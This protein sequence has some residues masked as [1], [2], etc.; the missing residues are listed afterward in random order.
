MGSYRTDA[1]R[2]DLNV[3]VRHSNSNMFVQ[4]GQF[5]INHK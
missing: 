1:V 3:K 2:D 4:M 5:L